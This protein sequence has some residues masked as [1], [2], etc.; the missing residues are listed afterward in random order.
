MYAAYGQR[1]WDGTVR[2]TTGALLTSA[3]QTVDRDYFTIGIRH[4]F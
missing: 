3:S 4:L 1:A 2:S